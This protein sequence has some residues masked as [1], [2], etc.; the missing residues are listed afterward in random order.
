MKQILFNLFE[1]GF[2]GGFRN[3]GSGERGDIDIHMFC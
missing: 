1:C 2:S 3:G